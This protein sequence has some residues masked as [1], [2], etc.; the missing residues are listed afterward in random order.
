[1]TGNVVS[2]ARILRN[3]RRCR[4]R[5]GSRHVQHGRVGLLLL[6]QLRVP[7]RDGGGRQY[8]MALFLQGLHDQ[9]AIGRIIVNDQDCRHGM[10][11]VGL[12]GQLQCSRSDKSNVPTGD[13]ER[14]PALSV[15]EE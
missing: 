4:R 13:G 3:R 14:S 11:T 15:P 6:G 5:P 8:R 2:M 10:N 1:M 12:A 9:I 7:R